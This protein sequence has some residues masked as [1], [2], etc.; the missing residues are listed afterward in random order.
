MNAAQVI[1]AVLVVA[2]AILPYLAAQ[3][4]TVVPPLAKVIIVA[5][6]L[7][8]TAL[9]LYLKVNLPGRESPS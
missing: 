4:E 9:A 8:V 6:N 2:S 7:G 1:A 3:P 5:A